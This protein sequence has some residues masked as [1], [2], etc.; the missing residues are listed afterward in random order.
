[1]CSHASYLDSL[2]DRQAGPRCLG[3]ECCGGSVGF[4]QANWISTDHFDIIAKAEGNPTNDE[5]SLMLRA[6]LAERFKLS[7]RHESRDRPIF[8]LQEQL[9]LKLQPKKDQADV[10]VIDHVEQPTPD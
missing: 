10:L 2:P 6:L 8:A 1:L 7:V 4:Q 5:F 9:G 3:C